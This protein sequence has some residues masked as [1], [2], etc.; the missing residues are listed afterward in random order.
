MSAPL[1]HI[2]PRNRTASYAICQSIHKHGEPVTLEEGVKLHGHGGNP[3]PSTIRKLYEKIVS[4]EW[5]SERNDK[6]WLTKNVEKYFDGLLITKDGGAAIVSAKY[7]P[8]FKERR[9]VPRD[10]RLR[11][12]SF[13]TSGTV[14]EPV[15][16]GIARK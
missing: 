12:I 16:Q 3:R 14:A 1:T 10:P 9:A 13:I 11:E 6:Y 4:N 15:F 7:N 8:P 5:L 2:I